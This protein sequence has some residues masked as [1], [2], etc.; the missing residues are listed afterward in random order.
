MSR[1]PFAAESLPRRPAL[2]V[3]RAVS[4][5]AP[6]VAGMT[7]ASVGT[8]RPRKP[9]TPSAE[10]RLRECEQPTKRHVAA[11][12]WGAFGEGGHVRWLCLHRS[13]RRA[14]LRWSTFQGAQAAAG[15]TGRIHTY[16]LRHTGNS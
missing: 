8:L 5:A 11:R 9:A 16:D 7:A 6:R 2:A 1:Q 15:L 14:Q 10:P 4:D 12:S 3:H 13:E